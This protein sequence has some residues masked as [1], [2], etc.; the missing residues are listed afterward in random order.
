MDGT[1]V[2]S[3]TEKNVFDAYSQAVSGAAERVGPAV[4]RIETTGRGP[5][6]LHRPG[7]GGTP[8]G[9]GSGVIYASDGHVLTNAHV[10]ERAVAIQVVLA[11]GRRLKAA[12][13]GSEPEHDLAILR[14][15]ARD[16]PVAEL[17]DYTL[18]VGQLV[19]AIGNPYGFG[20]TVTAGV[21]SAVGREIQAAPG[22]WLRQLVQTDAS[23]NPGNSGGPLVDGSGRVVGI[24]TAMIPNAQ[25]VGFAMPIRAALSVIGR[26][27]ER[28]A[29]PRG[30]WLGVGGMSTRLDEALVKALRL[31][32]DR[33]VL[34]LE[35]AEDSPAGRVGLK[36]L[37]VIVTVDG[38]PVA[39]P[40]ELHQAIA[41]A[42]QQQ[43]VVM[44]VRDS[45]LRRVTALIERS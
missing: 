28:S 11:D 1:R 18:R 33:G 12:L 36:L 27:G 26:L 20:W 42:R 16:L 44:F 22:R 45:R 10:I 34:L 32:S 24:T 19:V 37:D 39:S 38:R 6:W 13:V 9:M 35:V 31:S 5:S 29:R 43:V 25:G 40:D 4:V 21:V 17:A 7:S 30:P 14:I 41:D 8:S 23:I 15:G 2:G 3:T